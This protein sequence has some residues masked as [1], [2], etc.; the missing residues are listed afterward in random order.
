MDDIHVSRQEVS[1]FQFTQFTKMKP[2][3][4]ILS[5][6]CSTNIAIERAWVSYLKTVKDYMHIY[7]TINMFACGDKYTLE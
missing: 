4:K 3:M 7:M 2:V 1:S 6:N 5:A